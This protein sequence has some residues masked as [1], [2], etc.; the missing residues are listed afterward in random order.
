M[1]NTHRVGQDNFPHFGS[2]D[3]TLLVFYL[4]HVGTDVFY[5]IHKNQFRF[6]VPRFRMKLQSI[7]IKFGVS[8]LPC[9]SKWSAQFFNV[10]VK[11]AIRF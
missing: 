6:R 5:L 10:T 8:S 9:G 7:R 3:D 2:N 1:L 4:N 11:N